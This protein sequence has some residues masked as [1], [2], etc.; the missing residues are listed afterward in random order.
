M[1]INTST[2]LLLTPKTEN[3]TMALSY[4]QRSGVCRRQ[5]VT[6][7]SRFLRKQLSQEGRRAG[8]Q[9]GR[10]TGGLPDCTCILHPREY[11]IEFTSTG[12]LQEVQ[13]PLLRKM[14]NC[15][16]SRVLLWILVFR[17]PVSSSIS[18][19]SKYLYCSKSQFFAESLMQLLAL[20]VSNHVHGCHVPFNCSFLFVACLTTNNNS[21]HAES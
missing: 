20:R 1:T 11:W 13:T 6:V 16:T 7:C 19:R 18:T 17:I 12:I 21:N 14:Y 9:E 15:T 2:W 3:P 8:G 5:D 4:G 10:R